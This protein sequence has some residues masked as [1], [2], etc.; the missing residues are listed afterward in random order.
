MNYLLDTNVIS[1]LAP[2]RADRPAALVE[3]IDCQSDRLYLSVVAAAA[4]E[5]GI[6]KAAR[7]GARSKAASLSQWWETVRHF[8]GERILP[9]DLP[10]ALIAGA[11]F[12]RSRALGLAPGFA[13]IAIA[14]IAQRHALTILTRNLKH[15]SPLHD[16][17]IDPF[18]ELPDDASS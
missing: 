12:D 4:I 14:A 3:W 5:A 9:L 7:E 17:V 13:D 11:L 10:A 1:S 16:A 6:R 8:Y 18:A 15:F 2:T